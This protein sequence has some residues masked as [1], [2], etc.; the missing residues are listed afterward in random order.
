MSLRAFLWLMFT[1]L[2]FSEDKSR[3]TYLE[4]YLM[5]SWRSFGSRDASLVCVVPMSFPSV[6]SVVVLFDGS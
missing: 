2:R 6:T 3:R 1:T 4:V 5:M